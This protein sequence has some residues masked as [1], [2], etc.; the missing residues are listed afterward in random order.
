MSEKNMGTRTAGTSA[1][2]QE[3]LEALGCTIQDAARAAGAMGVTVDSMCSTEFG[4]IDSDQLRT[5]SVT[6]RRSSDELLAIAAEPATELERRKALA[7]ALEELVV[8]AQVLADRANGATHILRQMFQPSGKDSAQF[9]AVYL[10]VDS[11]E[12]AAS[13]FDQAKEA[14]DSRRSA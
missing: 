1:T 14:L 10:L 3:V 4:S 9:N 8:T 5:L 2:V 13:D 12:E 11:L 6:L 7:V